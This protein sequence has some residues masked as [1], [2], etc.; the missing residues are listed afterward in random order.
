MANKILIQAMDDTPPQILFR[1]VTDYNP[2][3][4]NILTTGT[5]T[6]VQLDLT[7]LTA[8]EARQ[9]DKFDFGEH[10]AP[11]YSIRACFEFA[12]GVTAGTVLLLYFAPSQNATAAN[13]NAGGVS[14][15]DSDYT[16]DSS[17]LS[18]ALKQLQLIG[19]FTLTEVATSEGVQK[20][21][22][23]GAIQPTERY[24][25]L[26]LVMPSSGATFHSDAI[27]ISIVFDPQ[28]PEIQ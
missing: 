26:V 25:T 12:A 9:S 10:R 8:S 2:A 7:S 28:V 20:I 21:E 14:G 27:E 1:D 22:C 16:G 5:P 11:T 3:T 4:A 18:A 6:A 17:N 24:G 19:S 15:S 13:A 23:S